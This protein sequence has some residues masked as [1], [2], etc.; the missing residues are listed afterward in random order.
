MGL[1]TIL[2]A[3]LGPALAKA[4]YEV[5]KEVVAKPLMGPAAEQF[6]ARVRH[7][8]DARVDDA[9]VCKAVEAA[10]QAAGLTQWEDWA[11]YPLRA[12][13]DR[14]AGEGQDTLRKQTVA[15]ALAMTEETPGQVPDELLAALRVPADHRADLARFLWAFR[16]AL[17]RADE[18]YLALIELSGGDQVRRLLR[19]LVT[20][21][22]V[23]TVR[24]ASKEDRE[25]EARYLSA[26]VSEC[27]TLP[28]GGRDYRGSTPTGLAVPLEK[29]Y[30]ALNTTERPPE[31]RGQKSDLSEM[32][33]APEMENIS[34]LRILL[35]HRCLVLLG[36]PGSGKTTFA[37][38]LALCLAGERSQ[39]GAGWVER[40][41][42]H[43]GDWDGPAL[44]PIRV[45]LRRFA[46]DADCLPSGSEEIG[47]AEHLLALR[48]K[49][50]GEGQIR[51]RSARSRPG[52]S[53][54]SGRCFADPGRSGRGRRPGPS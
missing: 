34:V 14:L 8:Y 5:G 28:L 47:R 52:S 30:I 7:G 26:V 16:G 33:K 31:A 17:A 32:A 23:V 51:C 48:R 27:S 42:T 46:A 1:G 15:A 24:I 10:V 11:D 43:D 50:A 9:Q 29:V 39:P 13:L 49:D 22:A 45:R 40:L 38:H 21:K 36:E 37:D 25:I 2:L 6:E 41:K 44:L 35:D 4:L 20:G 54:S 12:A 19:D 18:D 3:A 53:G